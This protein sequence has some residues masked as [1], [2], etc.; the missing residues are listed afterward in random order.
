MF[1]DVGTSGFRYEPD[2]QQVAEKGEQ[3]V[4]KG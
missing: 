2:E 1:L 4:E 3:S